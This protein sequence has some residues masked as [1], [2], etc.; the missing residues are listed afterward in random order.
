MLRRA[1]PFDLGNE[2][3]SGVLNLIICVVPPALWLRSQRA[4]RSEEGR[5]EELAHGW[6]VQVA[7]AKSTYHRYQFL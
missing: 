1:R 4:D 2:D 6:R 5:Y 3:T 7:V